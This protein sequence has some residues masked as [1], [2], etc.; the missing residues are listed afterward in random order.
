MKRSLFSIAL[1]ASCAAVAFADTQRVEGEILVKFTPS[2]AAMSQTYHRAIGAQQ[3]GGL[4]DLGIQRDKLPTGVSIEK[5]VAYYKRLAAVEYAEQNSIYKKHA[6]VNDPLYSQQ[7][8]PSRMTVDL[9]W[10]LTTGNSGVVVAVLDTG[11][12]YNH[13]D[14]AGKVTKGKDWADN[15]ADPM[16]VEGHGTHV[17][18]II[19][20]KTNNGVGIAG[21]G[22]NVSI[23]AIR[24][25]GTGGGTAEWVAGGIKEATDKGADVINMSLGSA[26]ASQAI[27]DAVNYAWSKGVVIVASAGNDG[28]T[29]KNYPG[30]FEKVICVAATDKDDLKADFSNYGSD[31]VDVAAPGVQIL[32]TVLNNDYENYDGTSMASPNAAGVASLLISYAGKGS[33]TNTEV[34]EIMESTATP[35]GNFVAKG[36]LNAFAAISAAFP[37]IFTSTVP[38]AAAMFDG[39]TS[40]GTV[41]SLKQNDNLHFSV[42][43]R[44]VKDL[45]GIAG[46]EFTLPYDYSASRWLSGK[47]T[48]RSKAILNS[49]ATVFIKRKSGEYT[50]L[51]SFALSGSEITRTVALPTNIT[52][53]LSGGKITMVIR[54]VYPSRYGNVTYTHSI[55]SIGLEAKTSSKTGTP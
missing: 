25:L 17:A 40:T 43:S 55:N 33:I 29:D 41:T 50:V 32:S 28:V 53:Y 4:P 12:D 47:L 34:R 51:R 49:T 20:A 19:G 21:I 44:F 3:I 48:F 18:G 11:V 24:V 46:T 16:D 36:R 42:T 2:G 22:Y 35:V 37:P 54:S 30:A 27:E 15:D 45:G 31:W 7:Y 52:P 5:A 8:S 13:P 10:D 9:G 1:A 39:K 38:N 6:T 26:S 23:L 14:L